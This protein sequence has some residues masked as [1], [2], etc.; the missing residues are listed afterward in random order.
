MDINGPFSMAMLNSQRVILNTTQKDHDYSI[1]SSWGPNE[2]CFIHMRRG[3]D[4]VEGPKKGT[5]RPN[6]S[7]GADP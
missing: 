3:N 1:Y 7:N 6:K 4:D 5:W 2:G